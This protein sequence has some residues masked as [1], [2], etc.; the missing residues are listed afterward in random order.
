MEI[1]GILVDSIGDWVVYACGAPPPPPPTPT[2]LPTATPAQG[3]GCVSRVGEPAEWVNSSLTLY[4]PAG[5]GWYIIRVYEDQGASGAQGV[6]WRLQ[7]TGFFLVDEQRYGPG[8][9]ELR[10]SEMATITILGATGAGVA[11]LWV[12]VDAVCQGLEITPIAPGAGDIK[13]VEFGVIEEGSNCPISLPRIKF[14]FSPPGLPAFAFDFEGV[15]ICFAY[16]RLK[17]GWGEFNAMDWAIPLFSLGIVW[18]AWLAL[19]RG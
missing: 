14:S 7:R 4:G 3:P 11:G 2:P 9:F 1:T 13:P 10:S 16:K 18:S 15:K 19:R 8:T 12:A 17:L 6:R 5:S